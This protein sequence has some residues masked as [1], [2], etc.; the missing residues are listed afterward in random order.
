MSP[1][2]TMRQLV[3]LQS[4]I[5]MLN[6]RQKTREEKLNNVVA[7]SADEYLKAEITSLHKK[8]TFYCV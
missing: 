4:Q 6:F 7:A 3:L 5:R 8:V 1:N 2:A